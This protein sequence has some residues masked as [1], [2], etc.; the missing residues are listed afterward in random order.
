MDRKRDTELIILD[1]LG[2]QD[3]TD[4]NSLQYLKVNDETFS[5]KDLAKFQNLSAL[6]PSLLKNDKPSIHPKEEIIKKINR[7]I[8]GRE[9]VGHTEKYAPQKKASVKENLEEVLEKNKID[10]GSLAVADSTSRGHSGFQ[11]VK[12][13][14]SHMKENS[15]HLNEFDNISDEEKDDVALIDNSDFNP[16]KKIKNSSPLK[17]YVLVSILLFV[18]IVSMSAY[19]F[20]NTKPEEKQIVEER[21][22]I[23]TAIV[24]LEELSYD[25]LLG[26]EPTIETVE[27]QKI[28]IYNKPQNESNVLPKAPPKLPEMIEAPLVTTQEVVNVEESKVEEENTVPPPKEVVE[29]S[30]EPTYFVAV[31]EMPQ[32]IG[33][34][35][36][37]QGKIKYPEIARRAG[38]EGKVFVRA[39]VDEMGN[40]VSVEL[41]KGIGGGCDEAALDAILNTKFTPGKQRGKPIKVQ[42][43]VPVLFKL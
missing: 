1:V 18:V 19:L 34:L 28:E 16:D 26:I 14:T 37:I 32:P 43:T 23:D 42:V 30:E 6:L 12:T 17:K 31:E 35:Q 25:S 20:I 38:V 3:E 41:V 29:E 24:K 39:F 15:A 27:V 33:G 8:F 21:K 10:W 5:W 40:V 11:E 7:L 22:P 4:K 36:G 9:D 2:C 13:K